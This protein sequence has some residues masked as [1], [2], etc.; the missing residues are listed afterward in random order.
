MSIDFEDVSADLQ[1]IEEGNLSRV[2][3]LV[4]QQLA[5]E[6]RVEDLE[7]D[8]AKAQKDLKAISEDSLPATLAE[9]G[10][11][12]LRMDDGSEITVSR[13]YGASISKAKQEEAFTW[14]RE[15]GHED[16]IKNQLSVSFGRENDTLAQKLRDRLDDEGYDTA[17]KV[18]VEPMTLKAFV[19]EQ[20]ESGAPIPTET[21]GIFIGEKAKITRRK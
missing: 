12:K 15:N 18:W 7:F 6:K 13:Y 17:Q 2:A 11:T 4:R 21:F 16:L 3:S 19:K 1:H 20:V 8:L 9:V 10:M 14:L 5:L